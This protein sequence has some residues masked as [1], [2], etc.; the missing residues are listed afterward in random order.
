[1]LFGALVF[2]TAVIKENTVVFVANIVVIAANT[3]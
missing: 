3:V 2:L 1:M